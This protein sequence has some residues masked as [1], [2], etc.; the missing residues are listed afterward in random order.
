MK[1]LSLCETILDESKF[2][3]SHKKRILEGSG[4]KRNTA[5]F[6]SRLERYALVN[7]KMLCNKCYGVYD[8]EEKGDHKC[9]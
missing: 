8:K 3:E 5:P 1:K 4:K 6:V 2:L 7:N 9:R